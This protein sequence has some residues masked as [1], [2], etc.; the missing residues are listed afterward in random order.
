[1]TYPKSDPVISRFQDFT[2]VGELGI[3]LVLVSPKGDP[4]NRWSQGVAY[5]AQ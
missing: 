2:L 4:F 3:C 5:V 1:M